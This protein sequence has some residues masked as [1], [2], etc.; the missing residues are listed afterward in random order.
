[1]MLSES[2]ERMVI[3]AEQGR[4]EEVVRVFERWGL[5][6]AT[7]GKVTDDGR[8]RIFHKRKMVANL[9]IRPLTNGAPMY[10]RPVKVPADLAARQ[11][12]P[13]LPDLKDPTAALKS[14]LDTPEMG[15]KAWLWRQYDHTVR[16]NTVHGPGGD[17]AVMLLKG[18]PAG[19][20]LTSDVNP[21]YCSLDP[22]QGGAQ[23]VAE[24][25]R[26]LACVGAEPVGLT[27]CL[28]FGNPELPEV[29]WQFREC[30]RGISD[31]CRA[32]AVPVVS[33]NVSFYNDT[34]GQSIHPT[35]TV[36]MVGLIPDLSNL[37]VAHFTTPGDRLVLLGTDSAEFGGSAYLRL[38][39]GIEQGRPPGVELGAEERLTELMR[40]AS[41]EGWLH[42][43]HD[44]S[45]GGLAIALAESCFAEGIG[46]KLKVN[47]T[48]HQLFSESQARAIVAVSPKKVEDLLRE[49]EDSGVPAF[50][51]GEV[52]GEKLEVVAEGGK[53]SATVEELHQLW[54]TALPR[55]LEL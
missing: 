38:L 50:E 49:A 35:P 31:A 41:F 4:E 33:G 26:N 14:L 23:A 45:E 39:H 32:L 55:A 5:D 47:L 11:E 25:V 1:M 42:T 6:V 51:V 30:I 40:L 8:A 52:G 19:L 12:A 54:A 29:S 18:T 2:Q 44:I 3:V 22:Y 20:A 28:N 21:V 46:A 43:E 13:E 9:P 7:I 10:R 53:I 36:A 16:T 15:S 24:A 17:A 27:D 48:P 34:E 37:P